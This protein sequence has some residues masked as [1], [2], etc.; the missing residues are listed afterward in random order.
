MNN[1]DSRIT[2]VQEAI[3]R[4]ERIVLNTTAKSPSPILNTIW[5]ILKD[6]GYVYEKSTIGINVGDNRESWAPPEIA[7]PFPDFRD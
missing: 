6:A 1:L 3:Q 2:Q 7:K 4:R 5:H